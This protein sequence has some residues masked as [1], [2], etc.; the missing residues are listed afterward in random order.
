MEGPGGEQSRGQGPRVQRG[1]FPTWTSQ[2]RAGTRP[3]PHRGKGTSG[4]ERFSCFRDQPLTGQVVLPALGA[5]SPQTPHPIPAPFL[6]AA[7]GPFV[8]LLLGA[9][10]LPSPDAITVPS[11][12]PLG[13][14]AA[15]DLLTDAVT[16]PEAS[17][18]KAWWWQRSG[19]QLSFAGTLAGGS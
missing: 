16:V 15:R 12:Q 13:P 14:D 4:L 5:G 8:P 11:Q 1:S 19:S 7:L 18:C 10:P 3:S 17:V 2:P 9:R 6:P